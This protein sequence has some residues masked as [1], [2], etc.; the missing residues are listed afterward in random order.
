MFRVFRA[1]ASYT[2]YSVIVL[3]SV[4]GHRTVWERRVVVRLPRATLSSDDLDIERR[5]A[6]FVALFAAMPYKTLRRTTRKA[7]FCQVC[8]T[9]FLHRLDF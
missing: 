4:E 2:L 9:I 1:V 7:F 3:V 6:V 8:D 5:N